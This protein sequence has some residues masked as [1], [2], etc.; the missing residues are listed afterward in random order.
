MRL[1]E[2]RPR[3]SAPSSSLCSRGKRRKRQQRKPTNGFM[4]YVENSP[5]PQR[6][7][8]QRA[9]TGQDV[10][11]G[12]ISVGKHR[13]FFVATTTTADSPANRLLFALPLY[14]SG[15]SR[16]L[17]SQPSSRRRHHNGSPPDNSSSSSGND[18]G[19]A[20][21]LRSTVQL[22]ESRQLLPPSSSSSLPLP[23]LNVL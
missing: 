3:E 22:G 4:L 7:T 12:A 1:H 8:R 20:G 2:L 13:A 16:L 23:A 5:E 6:N 17:Q 18:N 9:R 14:R 21:G 19:D 15:P 11:G 10:R